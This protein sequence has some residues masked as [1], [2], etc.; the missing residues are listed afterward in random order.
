MP[1][2]NTL[3]KDTKESVARAVVISKALCSDAGDA[4]VFAMTT[5]KEGSRAY[6]RIFDPVTGVAPTPSRIVEDIDRVFASKRVVFKARGAHV[7]GLANRSGHRKPPGRTGRNPWGGKRQK[8]AASYF[9]FGGEEG[10][11]SEWCDDGIGDLHGDVKSLF[12]DHDI[13][14][15]SEAFLETKMAITRKQDLGANGNS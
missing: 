5:P 13:I 8:K 15:A 3:N 12:R 7:P 1:L 10:E 6:N 11:E 2:D 9:L 14:K 4:R